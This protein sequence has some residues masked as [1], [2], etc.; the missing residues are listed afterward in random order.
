ML[1]WAFGCFDACNR[2]GRTGTSRSAFERIVPLGRGA[3]RTVR[4]AYQALR[5]AWRG[6][7]KSYFQ[8]DRDLL[9]ML[10]RKI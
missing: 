4:D 1:A 10:R 2:P 6:E 5:L 9:Q 8:V 7:D 3:V